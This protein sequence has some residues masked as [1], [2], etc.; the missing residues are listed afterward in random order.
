MEYPLQV[1]KT[2]LPSTSLRKYIYCYWLLE[3]DEPDSG[4]TVHRYLPVGCQELLVNF[5][6]PWQDIEMPKSSSLPQFALS[7]QF[8]KQRTFRTCGTVNIFSISFKPHGWSLLTGYSAS[9]FSDTMTDVTLLKGP[10][11]ELPLR[12]VARTGQKR[13]E[14]ANHELRKLFD[15]NNLLSTNIPIEEII[16]FLHTSRG[17]VN[18]KELAENYYISLSKLERNFKQLVGLTIKQY[19]KIMR[20]QQIL[21]MYPSGGNWANYLFDL[22]YFDQAHFSKDFKLFT[23]LAPRKYFHQPK[24]IV[25]HYLLSEFTRL[26]S[27]WR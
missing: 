4:E 8:T 9:E 23:G 1:Y 7:G 21:K 24:N 6:I 11:K 20:L 18:I 12:L 13:A 15:H 25:E 22:G 27:F 10:I 16:K 26:D 14:I 17:R 3:S 5:G 2:F 19:A